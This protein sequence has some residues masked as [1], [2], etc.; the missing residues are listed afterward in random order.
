M[1]SK[2]VEFRPP[3][4]A[5]PEGTGANE[6]FDLVCTFRVKDMGTVCL[7]KMGDTEMPGYNDTGS[8]SKPDYGDMTGG[9]ME[10][11]DAT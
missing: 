4:G 7:V 8:K 3:D 2:L 9:M 5:V 6:E 10:S 11:E 1:K